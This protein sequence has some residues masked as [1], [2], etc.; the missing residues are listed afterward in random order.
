LYVFIFAACELCP[1]TQERGL[2]TPFLEAP[3]SAYADDAP[4][5]AIWRAL[6]Q[7]ALGRKIRG[8]LGSPVA[9]ATQ[10]CFVN[11]FSYFLSDETVLRLCAEVDKRFLKISSCQPSACTWQDFSNGFLESRLAFNRI[12][13]WMSRFWKILN[14]F[15]GNS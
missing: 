15:G 14:D 9:K 10:S 5:R 2:D 6:E 4:S 1:G 7:S 8:F 3:R 13:G 12:L 11:L